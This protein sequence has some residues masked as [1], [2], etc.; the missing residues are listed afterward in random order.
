MLS[1]RT[2][3]PWPCPCCGRLLSAGLYWEEFKAGR[4]YISMMLLSARLT[5]NEFGVVS[6]CRRWGYA[7]QIRISRS[8]RNPSYKQ[9]H[10][11]QSLGYLQVKR[12]DVWLKLG[13]IWRTFLRTSAISGAFNYPREST[14]GGR[15]WVIMEIGSYVSYVLCLLLLR[16]KN[17][18][19]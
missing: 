18:E 12:P 14:S 19:G 2:S 16:H 7:F 3:E 9:E 11:G 5:Y 1:Q 15:H 10:R 17:I 4:F 13:S 6:L 8:S